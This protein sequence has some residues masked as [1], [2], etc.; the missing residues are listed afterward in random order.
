M[1]NLTIFLL[2][3]GYI[4]FSQSNILGELSYSNSS[5]SYTS[6]PIKELADV[7]NQREKLYYS[8]L[9]KCNQIEI[10]ILKSFQSL[11]IDS[12]NI[13]YREGLRINLTKI[14][15]LKTEGRYADYFLVINDIIHDLEI[16]EL[17]YEDEDEYRNKILNEKLLKQ[18]FE[19]E[20]LKKEIEYQKSLNKVSNKN[21]K[22]KQRKKLTSKK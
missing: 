19:T 4:G 22:V 6:P 3:F 20:K 14:R 13:K 16:N 21:L 18:E 15:Y 17:Y 7:M 10:Y 8:N 11:K 9:N 5:S 12:I 1:R 2:L